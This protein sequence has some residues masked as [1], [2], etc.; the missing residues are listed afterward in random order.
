MRL[1]S[2]E[3]GTRIE[4]EGTWMRFDLL[5]R[6]VHNGGL[7]LARGDCN[8]APMQFQLI[9]S[10]SLSSLRN[11]LRCRYVEFSQKNAI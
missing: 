7:N 2:A 6:E 9:P 4:R 1:D 5:R 10:P 3:K 8:P 11:D